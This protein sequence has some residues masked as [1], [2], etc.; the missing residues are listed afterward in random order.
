[1]QLRQFAVRN[2]TCGESVMIYEPAN[3]YDYTLGG[4]VFVG[5]FVEIQGNT[6]VDADSEA[7]SHTFICE[8]ITLGVR[9]F[10]G[11]SVM[12]IND[13][14]REGKP[15]VDHNSWGKIPIDNSVSIGSRVTALTVTICDGAVIGAGS[16]V[17][18]SI[19]GRDVYAGDPVKLLRRL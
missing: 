8:Y 1:M 10:T 17:T 9:C 7:Q 14:P 15:G 16:M 19:T 2:I 18:K 5:P 3:L 11:H 4:S 12:F 13:M 6:Q